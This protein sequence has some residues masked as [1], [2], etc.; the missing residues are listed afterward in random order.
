MSATIRPSNILGAGSGLFADRDYERDKFITY[1]SGQLHSGNEMEGNRVL[2]FK[3]GQS[4]GRSIDAAGSCIHEF[5]RGDMVNCAPSPPA[6]NCMF[7]YTEGLPYLVTKYRV[8]MNE[9]FLVE[10]GSDYDWA[11]E[12]GEA[13]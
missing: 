12:E 1:Y 13:S 9:E 2:Q 7:K 11:Q 6:S 5:G 3:Q 8:R 4:K 10:Y